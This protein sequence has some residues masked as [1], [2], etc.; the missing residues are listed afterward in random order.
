MFIPHLVAIGREGKFRAV[1]PLKGEGIN[2]FD[3]IDLFGVS[4]GPP[5]LGSSCEITCNGDFGD[6]IFGKRNPNGIAEAIQEERANSN[7]AFNTGI[8]A[9]SCFSHS[10]V[11]WVI[12]AFL[13]HQ[14]DY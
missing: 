8:F 4:R 14:G 13:I 11:K 7:R 3:H 6:W 2:F 12:H 9:V 10:E 5:S 1:S